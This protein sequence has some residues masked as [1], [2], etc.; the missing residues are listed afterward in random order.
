[1]LAT[2]LPGGNGV[3]VPYS[4]VLALEVIT[5]RS[6]GTD[7]IAWPITGSLP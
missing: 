3:Q 4:A 1:M 6:R 2:T 7:L 5:R